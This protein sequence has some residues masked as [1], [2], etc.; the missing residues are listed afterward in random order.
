MKDIQTRKD[1][2]F[3]VNTFYSKLMNDGRLSIFFQN[4]SLELHLPK[5]VHFW[6]FVL[7]DELGYTTDLT[8]VH[9]KMPLQKED[10]DHWILLFNETIDENF[11]GELATKAKQRAFLI[12]WTIESKINHHK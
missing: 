3:F 4:L 1:I 6:A 9:S 7:L 12:G 2:E 5:M 11:S 8:K 10:F